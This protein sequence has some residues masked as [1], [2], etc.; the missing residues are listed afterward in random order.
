MW[1]WNIPNM[2]TKTEKVPPW[3]N[4]LAFGQWHGSVG[5]DVIVNVGPSVWFRLKHLNSCWT[6]PEDFVETYDE[7]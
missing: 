1:S 4:M 3:K 7:S 5:G 6:E 2:F